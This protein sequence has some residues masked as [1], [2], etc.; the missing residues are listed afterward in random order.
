MKHAHSPLEVI[1]YYVPIYGNYFEYIEHR[2]N[3]ILLDG[4]S[5]FG[6]QFVAPEECCRI[7]TYDEFYEFH[8]RETQTS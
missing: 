1:W 6:T 4:T 7:A 8:N 5:L 2:P 3:G